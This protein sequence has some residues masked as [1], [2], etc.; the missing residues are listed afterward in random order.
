M[1]MAGLLLS[2]LSPW[3]GEEAQRNCS[4]QSFVCSGII[5]RFISP[6]FLLPSIHVVLG[7]KIRI[8]WV[9]CILLFSLNGWN[10]S[11]PMKIDLQGLNWQNSWVIGTFIFLQVI[12]HLPW[13]YR[14][15]LLQLNKLRPMKF[16]DG[17]IHVTD[18]NPTGS[19]RS[20]F[21]SCKFQTFIVPSG[22]V[23]NGESIII[24][25]IDNTT[26]TTTWETHQK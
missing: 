26:F 24:H 22:S 9:K 23:G 10:L 15:E 18:I 20:W 21:G 7:V 25:S 19:Q 1:N 11:S 2:S 17:W 3:N 16:K 5:W 13:F 14:Y 12:C 8:I 4:I 6:L